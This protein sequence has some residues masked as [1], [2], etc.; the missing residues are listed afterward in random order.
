MR[1]AMLSRHALPRTH[2]CEGAWDPAARCLSDCDR[3]RFRQSTQ[4]V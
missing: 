3:L 2:C 1:Q 4:L